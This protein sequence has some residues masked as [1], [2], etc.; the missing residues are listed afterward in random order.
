MSRLVK[1][2]TFILLLNK[3]DILKSKLEAGVSFVRYVKSY[4]EGPNDFDHVC[5]CKCGCVFRRRDV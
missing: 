5:D 2:T 3:S 1:G 4:K